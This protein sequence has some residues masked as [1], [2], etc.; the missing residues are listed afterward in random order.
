[1]LVAEDQETNRK[2]M[3]NLLASVA[4]SGQGFDV[5]TAVNGK[6]AVEVWERWAPHLV[7]MDLG[8]P[9]MDGFEATRRI[10]STPQGKDTI[11]VG[12]TASAFEQD[13]EEILAQGCDDFLRKP[14]RAEE[15]LDILA[16]H[17]G[18]RFVYEAL[19]PEALSPS[20]SAR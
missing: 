1:M 3:V 14:Y 8:M 11:I 12:L 7:W 17:L 9:V 18:V 13:R 16:K 15:V 10:K 2:L 5:Q 20:P 6:E 4:V 19:A